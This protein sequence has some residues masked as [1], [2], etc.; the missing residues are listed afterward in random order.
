MRSAS[1]RYPK[2]RNADI[3]L[4]QRACNNKGLSVTVT[5]GWWEGFCRR[6][7]SIVLR[8]PAQ[9][10]LARAKASDPEVFEHY[11]DLL[12][13]TLTEYDISDKPM[14]IFNMDKTGVPLSPDL[15]KGV[16]KK[17][18]KAVAVT[19]GDKSQLTAVA[20][21]G[22]GG[23]CIPPMVIL[24]RKTLHPDMTIGELPGTI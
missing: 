19:S 24:D 9:L 10:S 17:G 12:E 16:F 23:F 11:L 5:H 20:C 14:Q 1:I 18:S 15:P 7:P 2:S 3:A 22:A 21:V 4:V 6:N 13:S 8:A